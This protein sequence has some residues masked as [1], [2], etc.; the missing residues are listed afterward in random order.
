MTEP[1]PIH[2]WVAK[3]PG[4]EVRTAL[5]RLR[6]AE[7]VA[8]IA[9]MPDVHLA[10][11]VCVGVA[12]A[13]ESRLLPAAVGSDIGC[14]MAALAFEAGSDTDP[15]LDAVRERGPQLLAAIAKVVP[16][17]RHRTRDRPEL[18]DTLAERT[19]SSPALERSKQ[20][21]APLQLGTL[22]RGNHFVELQV[23]EGGRPW[24]MVHTGSRGIGQGIR[25]WHEARASPGAGN[26]RS[27]EAE[28]EAGRAYLADLGWAL[29]YAAENRARILRRVTEVL[30]G[31]L[32][33]EPLP[34]TLVTCEH[35]FVRHEV[36]EGRSLW[37]HR[38]GAISAREGESGIIPGSMGSASFIVSGR[39]E[40]RSLCSSSHGAGRAMARGEARRRIGIKQLRRE[41]SG[42]AFD[43]RLV[44]RLRDEAPGAYKD[45]GAVMRAQRELTR[46][47]HRLR[48]L[49]A[50]KG[51]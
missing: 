16:I 17:I 7:G 26:L 37:V 42:V 40:P 49:M 29:D 50:F 4:A 43:E 5:E 44:D 1:A 36:H 41:M 19:L 20:R 38:K 18:P 2:Q 39:G 6:R 24:L 22:G 31:E 9:V 21:E 13:T 51:A 30:R 45:I 11:E 48:P 34:E 14:G 33:L 35:N 15:S 27:F 10:S 25:K 46:V 3:R 47:V 12:L 32:G 28:S 8:A 23:D